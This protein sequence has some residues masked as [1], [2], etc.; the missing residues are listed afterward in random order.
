MFLEWSR[1]VSTKRRKR[2]N[3]TV[4]LGG[5]ALLRWAARHPRWL[6][7]GSQARPEDD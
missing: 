3:L 2:Y 4:A 1:I 6:Q 7:E 5:Y